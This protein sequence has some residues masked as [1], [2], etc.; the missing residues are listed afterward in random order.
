MGIDLT[1]I[2]SMNEYY[3]Q[4]YLD[5]I[6]E[7]DIKD[8]IKELEEKYENNNTELPWNRLSKG[9]R[10][11]Y[12]SKREVLSKE[13]NLVKRMQNQREFLLEMY[14]SL[15]YEINNKVD[16]IPVKNDI[17]IPVLHEV[18]KSNG[19]PLLWIIETIDEYDDDGEL[20]HSNFKKVQYTEENPQPKEIKDL[21]LEKIITEY[22]FYIDEPPRFILLS[23]INEIILID[24]G[25]WSEKRTLN[26]KLDDILSRQIDST[27]KAMTVLLHKNTVCPED[28]SSFLDKL[29][30]N[31]HKHA[32]SVS[33]SLKYALRQSIEL[34]GNDAIRYKK[35]VLRNGVFDRDLAPQLTI[36]C[37]RYMYRILFILY[38][39]ARPELGYAP[40]K[41]NEYLKGY[42]IEHL[43]E[44][45]DGARLD[46]DE[47][48]NGTYLDSTIKKLFNLIYNGFLPSRTNS[49][50]Q[51]NIL[52]RNEE[53]D[54]NIFKIEPLKAHIFDPDKTPI[55]NTIKFRNETL[56]EV[57]KKMSISD[58]KKSKNKKE[59]PGRIS[60]AQ[61]GI[62]QLGA[63]YEALLSYK[64]FLAEEDLYEVKKAGDKSNELEVGYFVNKSQLEE[65]TEDEIVKD[66]D[67]NYKKYLKGTFIY[68]L[69]GREREK[70]ASYYTPE[71]LTQCLVKYSLK[72]LLKDKTAD[73]ILELK[74]CE[75]AMGSAAFLN[76]AVN[77]LAEKYLELKQKEL[78][79]SIPHD[80]YTLEKQK[81]KMYIADRNVYGVD[82]NP[83][84]VELA[85][86][87]LWLNTIYK[88]AFV[89]WFNLQ[90]VCGNSLIGARKQVYDISYLDKEK[91]KAERWYNFEPQRVMPGN[92]RNK[93]GVY[94][95]LLGDEGMVDYNDTVIKELAKENIDIM[96]AWRAK[97]NEGY[98]EEQI[99]QLLRLC[100]VIDELW[101]K[102]TEL[103][104]EISEKTKDK[105]SIYGHEDDENNDSA[106]STKDKDYLY[107]KHYKSENV[108]NSG[109]Y[110][111]LKLVMD[112][113]CSLWFWPIEKADLLP[114][115]EEFL[116]DLSLILE[117]DIFNI[118]DD[119]EQIGLFDNRVN[120]QV[121]IS[122]IT[123][124]L[125]KV[126]LDKLCSRIPRLETVRGLAKKYKFLHWELEF[127]DIFQI[128]RGFD[129]II[130]NPPWLKIEWKEQGVLGDIEP[131]LS[132]KSYTAVKSTQIREE[133][134]NTNMGAI[135]L[136]LTEY[137]ESTGIQN[138]L[139][140]IVNYPDLEGM[141]SNLY[142][143]FLPQGWMCANDLGIISYIHPESVYEEVNAGTLRSK[144]YSKLRIHFKF[145]NEKK[146][147]D[148][149][150]Q[151]AFGL[152]IYSN[153]SSGYFYSIS[154]L[155]EPKTIDET[156]ESDG[157]NKLLGIKDD[158][159]E[160]NI[161]GHKDRLIKIGLK[162]LKLFSK[163]YESEGTPF[164]KTRLP[165]IHAKQLINVLEV[166][167]N[168]DKIDDVFDLVHSEMLNETARQKDGT[169]KR[170]TKF[171]YK[172]LNLIYSGPH[173][174]VGNPLFKTPRTICKEKSDYDP[175]D[176]SYI[177]QGNE[178]YLP[179]SN[180][181]ISTLDKYLDK[182]QHT[183]WGNLYTENYR[184]AWR[185]R[186]AISGE[187]TL[188]A[189]IIPPQ[190]AHI[191][192]LN[193]M[194]LKDIRSISFISA[195]FSSIVYD[196]FIKSTGKS[197]LHEQA[198]KLPICT[199]KFIEELTLR[200][201]MLNCINKY[202]SELWEKSW[203]ESFKDDMWYK[204]DF[205]LPNSTFRRLSRDW[206]ISYVAKS[207]YLRRHILV[208]IDVITAKALGLSLEELKVVYRIQ[209]PVLQ[210]YEKDTWY[211]KN[212]RII[213]TNNRGLT[214]IGLTRDKWNEVKNMK[215]GTVE[216]TI[217]DDTI[218]EG[219]VE[220]TIVYE[221][222][223][224]RCD[225]E[226]DYEEVWKNFEARFGGIK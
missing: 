148:I 224:D 156:F 70:S 96:K 146:L 218:P 207:D 129:L 125:G 89:P 196:F 95:F 190:T 141:K 114:T 97:F 153:K 108:E 52:D 160:W 132:I 58:T 104:K 102:H 86:V 27:L 99:E 136:Y 123:D 1:G 165:S 173:I 167:S 133:I 211:D 46:T 37:L 131:K 73:D 195:Y 76:E 185:R 194:A 55:L 90:L 30:E 208:E 82:L 13:K 5:T 79:D 54:Y 44:I 72:E 4:H 214:G 14:K 204:D 122:D 92:T 93:N 78:N 175:I 143:C 51:L 32:T 25:K 163:L 184:I 161:T 181:E 61:L 178:N 180:Y 81:V 45:V 7:D 140:T 142:K 57:I 212:G 203:N 197:D 202:Y 75:P 28:D 33:E 91:S 68:R 220:R 12:Y 119:I 53:I 159:G 65:Y 151:A 158:N 42:S 222:P 134:F 112:Y 94:H 84:A 118:D 80:R 210:A 198:C 169:I 22:I 154:N 110:A 168:K 87:S 20:L 66:E 127:S 149:G 177:L 120:V 2:L 106:L 60:Y 56:I 29:N 41:S 150:N 152:N 223:F 34:L 10:K 199:D 186:L 62:N 69:A 126:N 36:E 193:S 64:G 164:N 109:P 6:L 101:K 23:N 117:G 24:R 216:H 179:R 147:F 135:S 71:V 40:M 63:V 107:N 19:L 226:K 155:F 209:F 8:I 172:P 215:S 174:G 26:F 213:F 11:T 59:R 192:A 85:E 189:G 130:G 221:A 121:K 124:N 201:N 217:I 157:N 188:I 39:E 98:T 113:W 47:E 191:H 83:I 16:Y 77:Q 67:G 74:I 35:E 225:R 18:K 115:R 111:R 105:L 170:N 182:I 205:R 128:N 138:Y 49:N 31:S 116:F 17:E 88:G 100:D 15:G 200:A 162:E 48:R 3:T 206:N 137:E 171:S 145:F 50:E 183:N 144:I 43:R 103:R 139:K 9:I 219:P 176:L 21:D 166:L 187:R 38:I